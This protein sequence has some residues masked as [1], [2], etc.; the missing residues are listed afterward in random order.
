M[1]TEDLIESIATLIEASQ[2]PPILNEYQAA[3]MT[4]LSVSWYRQARI[5]GEGPPILAVSRRIVR[6]DRD[7]LLAWFRQ[8]EV[9]R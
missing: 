8:H 3:K 1:P 9:A 4:G 6:Y 7:T 5:K 2:F